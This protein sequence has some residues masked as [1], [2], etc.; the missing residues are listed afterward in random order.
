MARRP[1]KQKKAGKPPGAEDYWPIRTGAA[2]AGATGSGVASG[3]VADR[4][5]P[6]VAA[7]LC[8]GV[9]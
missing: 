9:L 1:K 8:V 3:R 2:S 6:S 7:G 4:W 5:S